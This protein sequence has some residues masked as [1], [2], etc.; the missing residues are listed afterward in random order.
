M[1]DPIDVSLGGLFLI[2]KGGHKFYPFQL[3]QRIFLQIAAIKRDGQARDI[4]FGP[5]GITPD[6][7][8]KD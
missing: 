2:L 8:N 6:K 7:N 1:F 5:C 3:S 4:E